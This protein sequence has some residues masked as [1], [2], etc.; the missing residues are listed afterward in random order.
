MST[1]GLM[2]VTGGLLRTIFEAFVVLLT[3]ENESTFK[4]FSFVDIICI[5]NIVLLLANG[6]FV[7]FCT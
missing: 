7:K 5:L 2:M 6:C 4:F 3:G 1:L